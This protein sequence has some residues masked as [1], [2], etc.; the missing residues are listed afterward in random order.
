MTAYRE[1]PV[2]CINAITVA[3]DL[4][5]ANKRGPPLQRSYSYSPFHS[6]SCSL[7]HFSFG[8]SIIRM[9]VKHTV[10]GD[11]PDGVYTIKVPT[12]EK[13]AITLSQSA[14]GFQKRTIRMSVTF[15]EITHQVL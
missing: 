10:F 9:S 6:H 1:R 2:P 3:Q 15:K 11:G 14:K 13:E 12:V 5:D 8:Y 7:L 4:H